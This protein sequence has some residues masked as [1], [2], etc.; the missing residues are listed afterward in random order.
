MLSGVSMLSSLK[1]QLFIITGSNGAG[2]STYKQALFPPEFNDLPI[3]DG[4]IFYTLKSTEFYKQY[5]SSKE[6][7][8]LAEEA[9]EEEFLD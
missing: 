9:L 8:K 1:P 5:K 2:K 7:R 4:D 6:A 3:F